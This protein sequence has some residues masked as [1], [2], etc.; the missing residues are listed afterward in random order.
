[1][2]HGYLERFHSTRASWLCHHDAES[3][4][5]H[6]LSA[7]KKLELLAT[8]PRSAANFVKEITLSLEPTTS[9]H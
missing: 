7:I 9:R 6:C 1:M 4:C 3:E 2:T 8:A 5:Y